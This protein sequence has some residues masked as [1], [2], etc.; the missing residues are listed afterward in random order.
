MISPIYPIEKALPYRIAIVARPRGGDW[1]RDEIKSLSNSGITVLVSML[2]TEESIE[3]Q[4]LNEAAECEEIGIVFLH[5][6]VGD[7]SV[8]AD[9]KGFSTVIDQAAELVRSG[10]YLGV[11]CRASIGRSSVLAAAVLVR[12]GWVVEAAFNAIED[13]RG[14]PVPDTAEQRQWVVDYI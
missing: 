5:I 1:L 4:L 7:R 13:A 12:L 11:H 6:P 2:T 10:A 14:R 9:E 8:P 3:L